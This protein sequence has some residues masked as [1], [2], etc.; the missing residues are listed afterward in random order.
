MTSGLFLATSSS[1]SM[2][3]LDDLSLLG[4]VFDC[5]LTDSVNVIMQLIN[6]IVVDNYKAMEIRGGIEGAYG[7][8]SANSC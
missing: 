8:K 4:L 5:E 2:K 6:V 1:T 7:G 3:I